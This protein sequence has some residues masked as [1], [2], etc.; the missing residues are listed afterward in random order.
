MIVM[1]S[2]YMVPSLQ[3]VL[4]GGKNSII[5]RERKFGAVFPDTL[6]KR[7]LFA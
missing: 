4:F 6:D 7:F 5:F 2:V 1:L 3:W